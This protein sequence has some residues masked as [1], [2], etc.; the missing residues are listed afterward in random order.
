[1]DAQR[2]YPESGQRGK[3]PPGGGE[4]EARVEAAAEQLEVVRQDPESAGEDERQERPRDDE[5]TCD[6]D[7]DRTRKRAARQERQRAIGQARSERVA[8]QLVESV[9]PYPHSQEERA[10]RRPEP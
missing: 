4:P 1:M 7:P 5:E 10:Q 2:H 6:P 3:R 8:V 9:R